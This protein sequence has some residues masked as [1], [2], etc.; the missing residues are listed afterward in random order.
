MQLVAAVCRRAVIL[1]LTAVAI[2]LVSNLILLTVRLNS[3][4]GDIIQYL[5]QRIPFIVERP[6]HRIELMMHIIERNELHRLSCGSYLFTQ[7]EG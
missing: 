4:D 5:L 7:L 3:V 6:I 1:R 2:Q